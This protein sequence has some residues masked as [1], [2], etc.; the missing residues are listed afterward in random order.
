M[1]SISII[2]FKTRNYIW[3]CSKR[4]LTC[5]MT[6]HKNSHSMY[7]ISPQTSNSWQFSS[8]RAV[9]QH[10][11]L[12]GNNPWLWCCPE[13]SGGSPAPGHPSGLWRLWR[14][15]SFP[16][17]S[18]WGLRHILAPLMTSCC[19]TGSRIRYVEIVL[20]ML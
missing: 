12:S 8:W 1:I 18:P 9:Y 15:T 4:K 20:V 13:V 10:G 16:D 17:Y 7:H 11:G 14:H 3:F 5:T 2:T 6:S 19:D